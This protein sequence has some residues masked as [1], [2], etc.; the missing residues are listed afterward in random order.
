[1][2]AGVGV[3]RALLACSALTGCE[4]VPVLRGATDDDA[5]RALSELSRAGV[6]ATMTSETGTS[7]VRVPAPQVAEAVE[8]LSEAS[9]PR[10]PQPGFDEAW[11]TGSLVPSVT[12]TNERSRRATEG[13]V[14]RTLSSLTGVIDARVHLSPPPSTDLAGDLSTP[15]PRTASV[16]LHHEGR[17]PTYEVASVQRVVASAVGAMR[18]EDVSVIGVPRRER[19]ARSATWVTVGPFTVRAASAWPL[20]V[21]LGLSLGVNVAL[22][23]AVLGWF[24]RR[25]REKS[26]GQGA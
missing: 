15:A 7:T 3:A 11:G 14:A 8:V 24:V 23:G 22:A 13:E 1:M 17:R 26:V 10:R 2:R 20:R 21:A 4:G 16:V 9:L 18:P 6:A 12:E 19:G 5:R 25:R